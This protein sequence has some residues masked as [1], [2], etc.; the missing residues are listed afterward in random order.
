MQSSIQEKGMSC[1]EN[2]KEERLQDQTSSAFDLSLQS[3]DKRW[4][5]P[6]SC[7]TPLSISLA[8]ATKSLSN[9]CPLP[10]PLLRLNPHHFSPQL[11]HHN[12]SSL[13]VSLSA[14]HLHRATQQICLRYTSGHATLL[15]GSHQIYLMFL[16]INLNFSARNTKSSSSTPPPTH[17]T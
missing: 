7:W 4:G 5:H 3:L 6:P 16:V 2:N 17:P 14:I 13:L 15:P 8:L 10:P 11:L 12:Q 9:F 1:K